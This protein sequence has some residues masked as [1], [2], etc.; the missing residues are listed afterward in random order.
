MK[1]IVADTTAFSSAPVG[2]VAEHVK[3]DIFASIMPPSFA[4][5]YLVNTNEDAVLLSKL[6]ADNNQPQPTSLVYP[7]FEPRYQNLPMNRPIVEALNNESPLIANL[8]VDHFGHRFSH[9]QGKKCLAIITMGTN[10]QL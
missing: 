3:S 8:I 6:F 7:H 10:L 5:S 2:P 9:L 4:N 1:R